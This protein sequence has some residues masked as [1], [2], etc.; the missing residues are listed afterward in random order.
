MDR[1]MTSTT[2]APHRH[3]WDLTIHP[4][5]TLQADNNLYYKEDHDCEVCAVCGQFRCEVEE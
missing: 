2:E 4:S 5:E 1:T 3:E